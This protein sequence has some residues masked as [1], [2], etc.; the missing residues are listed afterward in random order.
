[1]L[2]VIGLSLRVGE[3]APKTK[4]QLVIVMS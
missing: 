4:M 1:L 2:S 3:Q